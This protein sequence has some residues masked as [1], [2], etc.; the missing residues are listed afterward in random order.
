M[1]IVRVFMDSPISL[2]VTR[3]LAGSS[4]EQAQSLAVHPQQATRF[5]QL[6]ARLDRRTVP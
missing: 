1:A 2:S 4:F 3:T 6:Q 5:G